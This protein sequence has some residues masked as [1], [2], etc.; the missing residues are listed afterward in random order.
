MRRRS[1]DPLE[2]TFGKVAGLAR[3]VAITCLFL[4]AVACAGTPGRG[5]RVRN[6]MPQFW[7]FWRAAQDKPA[8]EQLRLWHQLYERPNAAVFADLQGTCAQ[9]LAGDALQKQYFPI[10]RQ[11][12]PRMRSLS[13]SLPSTIGSVQE[14]FVGAFPDM[15]WSAPIYIMASAGCFNGRSQL[16]AGRKALLLGVDDIVGLG[17]TNLSPLITHEMFHRYHYG[18]FAFEPELPQ[19]PWVRLWA[20]GLATYVARRLNPTATNLELMTIDRREIAQLEARLPS[21]ASDFM[22]RLNSSLEADANL[23]FSDD[24]G[25]SR[26]LPR[27]GYYLGFRV[28][29]YLGRQYSMQALAHWSQQEARWHIVAAFRHLIDE[30]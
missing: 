7:D 18:Y 14:R 6:L 20:E 4:P 28:A 1:P 16:I 23:Y 27:A 11:W 21:V 8:D 17:E 15:R 9:D 5:I 3:I 24:S 2:R 29:E 12:V 22:S 30:K 10:L 13:A 19:P 25:S 26:V